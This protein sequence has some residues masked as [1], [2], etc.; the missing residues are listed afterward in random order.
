MIMHVP[1]PSGAYDFAVRYF[2]ATKCLAW[3]SSGRVEFPPSHDLSS[4]A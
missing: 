2:C 3:L 4:V 1:K